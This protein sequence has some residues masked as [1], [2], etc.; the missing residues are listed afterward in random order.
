MNVNVRSSSAYFLLNFFFFWPNDNDKQISLRFNRRKKKEN[1]LEPKQ[2][3][4]KT[5][6]KYVGWP[7]IRIDAFS[8]KM[9][10][11]LFYC[12]SSD[13]FR[14]IF[15]CC[16]FRIFPRIYRHNGSMNYIA[17][18]ISYKIKIMQI[19]GSTF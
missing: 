10:I 19:L 18:F 8:M 5:H 9:F 3:Q 7:N 4:P 2:Q 13:A 16:C 14:F 6:E 1:T 15:L 12:R 17:W 11:R